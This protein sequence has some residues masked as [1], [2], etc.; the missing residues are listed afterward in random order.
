MY[1]FLWHTNRVEP[2]ISPPLSHG[3][4]VF[5][6]LISYKGESCEIAFY[7]IANKTYRM[8]IKGMLKWE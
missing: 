7:V 4:G 5:Y 2:R 6:V 3:G 1:V 8:K